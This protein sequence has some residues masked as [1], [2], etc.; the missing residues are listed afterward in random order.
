MARY[1][2]RKGDTLKALA[3]EYGVSVKEL[4]KRNPK[5]A[6]M[7]KKAELDRDTIIKL[8]RGTGR[9]TEDAFTSKED[10]LAEI[11][12]REAVRG[13]RSLEG[14][15]PS[16]AAFMRQFRFDKKQ[17]KA[18][19]KAQRQAYANR[20]GRARDT[21]REQERTG[22]Q[23][24]DTSAENRGLYRSGQRLI[25]RNDLRARVGLQRDNE[26]GAIR[27]Q[28]AQTERE[29]AEKL[30]RLRRDRAEAE[31]GSRERL[32]IEAQQKGA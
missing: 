15:D 8:G 13:R 14:E 31:L 5:L 3:K 19:L 2:S 30:S 28:R 9:G 7:A 11:A 12:R 26:L 1:V 18:A 22:L 27:D 10:A 6:D 23:G 17:I 4:K 21:Y 20:I 25:D 24:I 16:F 32:S 29:A